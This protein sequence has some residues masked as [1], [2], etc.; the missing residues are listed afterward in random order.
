MGNQSIAMATDHAASISARQTA[1]RWATTALGLLILLLG[2]ARAGAQSAPVINTVAGT[3]TIGLTGDNGAAVQ[4]R[5]SNP[6]GVAVDAVGNVYIAERDTGSIRKVAIETGVI[7]R[8]AGGS[9]PCRLDYECQG[10]SGDGGLATAAELWKPA[11]VAVD[12]AANIY[13]ADTGNARIRKISAAT[14]TIVTIAGSGPSGG[15]DGYAGSPCGY[16]GDGGPA[17]AALLCYPYSVAVDSVGNVY[18]ADMGNNRIRMISAATGVITTVAGSGTKGFSGDGGLATVAD[19]SSPFSV[20]LDASDNLF[21][22][23]T[24]NQRIRKVTAATGVITT[25]AGTGVCKAGGYGETATSATLCNVMSVAV[26][27]LGDLFIADGYSTT[28]RSSRFLRVGRDGTT[29]TFPL[30]ALG[31]YSP[32]AGQ[33]TIDEAGHLY[34]ADGNNNRIWKVITAGT[35]YSPRDYQTVAGGGDG[36]L[37]DGGAAT[38][39]QLWHPTKVAVDATGNLY[40]ADADNNRI[41]KVEIATGVIKTI[42]GTGHYDYSGDGGPATAAALRGP[43]GVTV[44]AAGNVYIADTFNFRVRKFTASTGKIST[45]AGTGVYGLSGD[46][47]L[48][49][50]TALAGPY[51]VAVDSSGN[52]YIADP[53]CTDARIRKVTADTGVITTVA[54]IAGIAGFSGDGGPATAAR[55]F[56]PTGVAMDGSGNLYIADT[57]NHRVRK[58]AAGTGVITTVAG[59]GVWNADLGDGG[60][61]TAARLVLPRGVTLDARGNLYIAE[62]ADFRVRKVIA[63]TGVITTVAGNGTAGFSGDGGPATAAQLIPSSVAVDDDG[64]LYVADVDNHRIRKVRL[65]LSD[66]TP[67]WIT[68]V[69]PAAITYSTPLTG[70]QLNAAANVP[71]I[72]VYAPA[73]GTVLNAG[74][75]QTLSVT[76]TPADT[77]NYTTATKTATIDVTK[78][79]PVVTWSSPT[80]ITRGTTLGATQLNATANVAGTFAYTP[81]SGTILNEGLAQ[82]LSVSFTP[83]DAANYTTAIK[84]VT[85]DVVSAPSVTAHP[86]NQTVPADTG[87]SFSAVGTGVPGP[88]VQWQVST[89]SGSTWT[90]LGGAMTSTY[91]F[92]ATLGDSG[93]QYRA[94]FTNNLGSASTNAATLTVTAALSGGSLDTSF[95]PGAN[96]TVDVLVVQADGK[97]LVGGFF[98]TLGGGGTGTTTRNNIGRLNADG[99]LDAS[100]NPGANASVFALAVQADGKILVGGFFTTLGGGGTGTTTRNNIGRLNADGTLDTSFN[101]GAGGGEYPSVSTLAVQPD[102]KILVGGQFTRL[103]GG[104]TGTTTRNNIGRLNADGTLDA[105]FD[106]GANAPVLALAVQAGGKIL[107]GGNFTTLGGGGTGTTTNNYVGRLDADGSLDTNFN[108]NLGLLGGTI[109]GVC[110][111]AVQSDG[112]I[113]VGGFFPVVPGPQRSRANIVRLN[114]DGSLDVSFDSDANLPVYAVAVQV[115]GKILVG[116]AFTEL[117]G[118]GTGRTTRN[119]IGRF[120]A[121]GSLDTTFNPGASGWHVSAL[122]VQADGKILVG[123]YFTGLGGGTGT[124]PRNYLGRLNADAMTSAPLV[125]THPLNQTVTVGAIASFSAAASG[126]PTP[127]VQWQVSANSGSTWTDIAGATSNTY[128]LTAGL[129]DS[130]KQYRAVF[131]SS[132]GSATTNAA[133]LLVTVAPV[134]TLQ[135]SSA[136]YS[137]LENAGTALITVT[138]VGSTAGAVSVTYSTS[139]GSAR[140][141]VDYR[142]TSGTLS[143]AA[144]ENSKTF[145]VSVVDNTT[146]DGNRT[147]KL[148]VSSPVGGAELGSPKR[149]ILTIT[150]DEKSSPPSALQLLDP[151]CSTVTWCQGSYLTDRGTLVDDPT[152]LLSAT[153]TRKGAVADGVTLLLVRVQSDLPVTF[154]LKTTGGGLLVNGWGYLTRRDGSASG[155][156]VD[157]NPET[158]GHMAFALYHA[159]VDFPPTTAGSITMSVEARSATGVQVVP[160]L[161]M[162][163]PVVLV[164]GVWSGPDTWGSV[165]TDFPTELR[166]SLFGC[167]TCGVVGVANYRDG[168]GATGS[169]DPLDSANVV[170]DP[171]PVAQLRVATSDALYEMWKRDIAATQVDVVGHSEGGL[172][173]R[174]RV[175]QGGFWGTTS[176]ASY[177][178]KANYGRG[179]FHKIITVGTPHQ[180]TPLANWLVAHKCDPGTAPTIEDVLGLSKRPLGEAVYEFQT[181]SKAIRDLGVTNVRSHAIVGVAPVVSAIESLLNTLLASSGEVGVTVDSIFGFGGQHDTVVPVSSQRGGLPN[182]AVTVISGVVHASF[183]LDPTETEADA[184]HHEI[185]RL[186]RE[187]TAS[188]SFG[189][190]STWSRTTPDQPPYDCRSSV[191]ASK[192]MTVLIDPPSGAHVRPG[193]DIP[194]TVGMAESILLKAAGVWIGDKSYWLEG[195]GPFSLTYT[196]PAGRY[197][198]IDVTVAAFGA[199]SG[200]YLGSTSFTVDPPTAPDSLTVSPSVVRLERV[201]YRSALAITGHFADGSV[202][203]LTSTESGTTYAPMSGTNTVIEVSPDGVVTAMGPGEDGVIITNGARTVAVSVQVPDQLPLVA[204]GKTELRFS[205]VNSNGILSAQTGGQTVT[206]TKSGAG[207]VNWTA[208]ADQPW[209]VVSPETG[210]GTG[211]LTVSVANTGAGLPQIG[212]VLGTVAV[213]SPTAANLPQVISVQLTILP[214]SETQAPIGAFDTPVDAA[215]GLQGSFAVTGWALDDVGIDRVEIWR[216]LAPGEDSSHAYTT[217]PSHP[218]YGKVFIST[219]LFITGSRPDVEALYADYP[220]AD[221][222][223]WGYLLLSWGLHN[224]GNGN[225]TLYAYAYDVEGHSTLLGT[226]YINVD[227][228]HADKPFGALDTPGYGETQAGIFVNFG[229][230]LTPVGSSSCRINSG[231]V[232]VG[233]DSGPLVPAMYGDARPDIAAAFPS[234]LNSANASGAFYVDTTLLTNGRHQIGWLVTDSCGRQDGVGSRFF[235]VLNSGSG[236]TSRDAQPR[237]TGDELAGRAAM[238]PVVQRDAETGRTPTDAVAV[239]QMGGDW[240]D[241]QPD[242]DGWH[243]VDVTQGGRIEVQLPMVASGTYETF[244]EVLGQHRPLPSGSSFDAKVSIFYWQP[245]PAFLGNFD[246]VFEAPGGEVVRLRVVVK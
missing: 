66:A 45:V 7:T 135:F 168:D 55:L 111:L 220:L 194:V 124:T 87:V 76:F 98:T 152:S 35:E 95:N 137:V 67:P 105:S 227:N 88:T 198:K 44:D 159:P 126:T 224:Q 10:F 20:A 92:T 91:S 184:V 41:R 103:G 5:L 167:E 154:S 214:P 14:G 132:A 36:G 188:D 219:P 47:D 206:V 2:P 112:K 114:A 18:T 28:G 11:G 183:A 202:G 74:L 48:A 16:S 24:F 163:P 210:A 23:D 43:L 196:V 49:T 100:F 231:G 73:S 179:E 84:T 142:A 127:T 193:D 144:G 86:S 128:S 15:W 120:N 85:I 178:R 94:V 165:P 217:D 181:G 148:W 79:T 156:Q 141:G 239:R 83:S 9:T 80:T 29:W 64:N 215:T 54:G 158:E 186:L 130:G 190:F 69:N 205:A 27:G 78:A 160:L 170:A 175:A 99:S 246:L 136:T 238:P 185:I 182:S 109:P 212:T 176:D 133:T 164:H 207:T 201:G 33:M 37:G 42:A 102:G 40:V 200:V 203:D 222:A 53:G 225:Y 240:Q 218:A 122:A 25:V 189:T 162:R 237:A 147:I 241:V 70:T 57:N 65:G 173:A 60:P 236:D 104:G 172:V 244:E 110:A 177:K 199:A 174:A 59:V 117:S 155:S 235:N 1:R 75:G 131:T 34:V 140:A 245:A 107:V 56:T 123:G 71:G 150:D 243:I 211:V 3:G 221:R 51:D 81:G 204:L 115:N 89:N 192:T 8:V 17:T 197:G 121:D 119:N 93:K 171:F 58:V 153:V 242:A 134:I 101:P 223:G 169:F 191:R 216:D 39:A 208:T 19:L 68:W 118:G 21:I 90:D 195:Q 113:L 234:F 213:S 50:A 106:P 22:A 146:L 129:A 139:D 4:A 161:L 145:A 38:A 116:G 97:I 77:T 229:W 96:G 232:L 230:A 61:A 209:I 13:I 108:P 166:K 143:Y 180:G 6:S 228:A 157:V 26:D 226:K 31:L 233:I 151:A 72:F 82:T 12:G 62:L 63:R 149:A 52:L 187:P 138:R 46:G 32:A 125:T 30:G